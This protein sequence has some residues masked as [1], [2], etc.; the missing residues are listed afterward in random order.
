[1]GLFVVALLAATTF[2]TMA[3]TVLATAA[4]AFVMDSGVTDGRVAARSVSL[5]LSLLVVTTGVATA[6]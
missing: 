1:M 4:D 5:A 3:G 2:E 6:D